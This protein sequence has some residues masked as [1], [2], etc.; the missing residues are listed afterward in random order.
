MG[1]KQFILEEKPDIEF[2]EQVIDYCLV[3]DHLVYK[4]SKDKKRVKVYCFKCG[5]FEWID[6]KAF[7]QCHKANMC[8]HCYNPV[9]YHRS[10]FTYNT[11]YLFAINK[12]DYYFG[13]HLDIIKEFGKKAA[14]KCN[15]VAFWYYNMRGTK[16]FFTRNIYSN[17]YGYKY[18][19]NK[20]CRE[21]HKEKMMHWHKTNCSY[22]Y[23]L[24]SRFDV[25]NCMPDIRPQNITLKEHYESMNVDFSSYKSNQI[26]LIKNNYFNNF[27]V[28]AIQ[29]FN[30]KSVDEVMKYSR[31]INHLCHERLGYLDNDNLNVHHLDYLS[32]NNIPLRDYQDYIIDCKKLGIKFEKPKDFIK[33]HSLVSEEARNID[34]NIKYGAG[35]TKHYK[36]IMS[37]NYII[38]NVKIKALEDTNEFVNVATELHN[39][40]ASNYMVVYAKPKSKTDLFALYENNIPKVCIEV[41]DGKLEQVRGKYNNNPETK[42]KKI[43]SQWYKQNY[44]RSKN[45]SL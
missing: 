24:H 2:I 10:T 42:Y 28:R 20:T 9:Y 15:Q 5:C 21:W 35:I 43:V 19:D 7:E 40:V 38:D 30:L 29:I 18:I 36:K 44:E 41:Y 22:M 8:P 45:A 25:I 17:M 16:Q 1:T 37:K 26:T 33:T 23:G 6:R 14:Y 11:K 32:R 4:Y 13:Y 3:C 34:N 31:Y 39:C 12:G 27:Q